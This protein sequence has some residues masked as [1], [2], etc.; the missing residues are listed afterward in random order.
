MNDWVRTIITIIGSVIASSGFWAFITSIR[1][2]KDAKSDLLIAL[3]HDRIME[4]GMIYIQRG[5]IT[6]DE[7]EN[8]HDYLYSSYHKMGGNGS[9]ERI[10]KTIE[11][12]KLVPNDYKGDE[13]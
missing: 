13:H 5:W 9:A 8:L 7:Y 4:L 6:N 11:N 12:L 10:M 2:K 3:A 1:E